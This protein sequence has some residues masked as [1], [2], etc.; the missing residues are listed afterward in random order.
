MSISCTI[1]WEVNWHRHNPNFSNGGRGPG[2]EDFPE[3]YVLG[4]SITSYS[5]G[6]FSEA[7]LVSPELPRT[8]FLTC[9]QV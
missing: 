9:W 3:L 1:W 2:L 8:R 5:F 4:M 7:R 6:V